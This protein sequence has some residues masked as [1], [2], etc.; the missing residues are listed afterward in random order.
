MN[1]AVKSASKIAMLTALVLAFFGLTAGPS[2]ASFVSNN[3]SPNHYLDNHHRRK[4]ALAYAVVAKGEG[5]EWGGGCWNDNNRDDTPD[6][7]DSSGEGPDCSGLVF[8]SWELR[9][10]GD[11]GYTWYDKLENIHG[12][13]QTYDYRSPGSS[14]PFVRL[15]DKSRNTTMYMDAFAKN[16]HVGLLSNRVSPS[17]NTDYIIEARGDSYGTGE[18]LESYRYNSNYVAVKR[19]NWTPDCYPNCQMEASL[20]GM[21]TVP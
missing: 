9:W 1:R 2:V 19:R 17:S 20:P 16:G 4:D 15:P 5:Y 10:P 14:D 12:P 8:K 13:Y 3:C 18:W 21:V 7:P 6:A 11:N